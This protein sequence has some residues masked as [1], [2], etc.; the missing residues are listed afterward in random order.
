MKLKADEKDC[1]EKCSGD[2]SQKCG[3]GWRNSVYKAGTTVEGN[4][5]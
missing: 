1:L 5:V 3:G 2:E 4:I